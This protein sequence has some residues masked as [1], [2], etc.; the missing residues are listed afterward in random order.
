MAVL[1]AVARIAPSDLEVRVDGRNNSLPRTN[2]LSVLK[3][4]HIASGLKLNIE[5]RPDDGTL[6][7]LGLSGRSRFGVIRA[8]P[9]FY[10]G[11]AARGPGHF[12]TPL[13]S[14]AVSSGKKQEIEF[15]GDPRG[16]LPAEIE[17]LPR[18][19]CL[20]GGAP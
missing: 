11:R 17:I 8:L 12:Q 2:N 7:A 19:L 13:S 14:I 20:K 15:D 3:N 16:F 6:Y 4:P 9:G 10:S 5:L 18:V 1:L